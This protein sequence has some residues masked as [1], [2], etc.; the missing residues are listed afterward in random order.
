M[1]TLTLQEFHDACRAQGVPREHIALICPMCGTPQSAEDFIRAGAGERF[2][3]VEKV[4]GF[5]CVGRFT[6]APSP[7][8]KHDGKP[9]NWTLGGF[10][11]L[12]KLE[13]VTDDGKRHPRFELATPEAAQAHMK[14]KA[15]ESASEN[16]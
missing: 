11:Q 2:E 8:E 14:F 5:S 10:F 1:K 16:K 15:S 6:G 4:L 13:V 7:R 9:C 3:D 12:H